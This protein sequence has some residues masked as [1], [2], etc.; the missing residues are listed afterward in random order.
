MFL[1]KFVVGVTRNYDNNWRVT[2][3]II[4]LFIYF[5]YFVVIKMDIVFVAG[6]N[7]NDNRLPLFSSSCKS[8]CS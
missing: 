3:V 7:I 2:N 5:Y 6:T 1:K 4:T 8:Y